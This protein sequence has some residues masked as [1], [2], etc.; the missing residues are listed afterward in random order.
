[1]NRSVEIC[2]ICGCYSLR[3][4]KLDCL[5][6]FIHSTSPRA[7]N[8]STAAVAEISAPNAFGAS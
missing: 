6:D 3:G 7:R 4:D 8:P 5:A 1:L 2:E